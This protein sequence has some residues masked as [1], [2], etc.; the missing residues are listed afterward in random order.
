MFN[1]QC[2]QKSRPEFCL[3]AYFAISRHNLL[4]F[5]RAALEKSTHG[6]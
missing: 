3:K 6:S 5:E 4:A 2:G 1:A